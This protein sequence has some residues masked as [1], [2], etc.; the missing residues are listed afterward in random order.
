MVGGEGDAHL[1]DRDEI[2]ERGDHVT[3]IGARNAVRMA[4]SDLTGDEVHVTE[5]KGGERNRQRQ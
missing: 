5:N 3:V 2:V 1:P 4:M